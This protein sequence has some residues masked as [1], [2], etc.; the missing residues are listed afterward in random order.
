MALELLSPA[1]DR[2]KL[3]R[4]VAY[5]ADAVYLAGSQYGMRAFAGNFER[6][7]LLEAVQLCHSHGVAVHVT[8]NTNP[9]NGELEGLPQYLEFLAQ[10]QVDALIIGDPGVFRLALRHA[11][12]IPRHISTQAGITN[13]ESAAYWYDQGANRVILARELS[14]EEVAGIK[15]RAPKG[16]EVE[17]FVHGAICMAYSGRCVI[18]N[19]MTGR[20][21][22]RGACAQPC[23]Y[24][25]ALMEEQ[26]PGEYFPVEEDERGSYLLS[27]RDMCMID[28][29]PALLAAGVDSLKIEGRAKSAYYAAIVTGAYRRAIDAA[30]RGEP[31]EAVWREEVEKVS[32]RHYSTGFYY[33]QPGQYTKDSR[34]IRD[35][36]VAAQVVSCDER[37]RAALTLHNKLRTGDALELVGPGLAPVAFAAGEMTDEAGMSMEEARRPDSLFYMTLPCPAP[38]FSYLRR[39]VEGESSS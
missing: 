13:Y 15:S 22:T 30:Q 3:I 5:G 36:Q 10:A 21:A 8:C 14:L 1:G 29:I 16:L 6:G 32:H 4:A 27:S 12:D 35:W 24:R 17:V 11:P 34:Y 23:R 2:E 31:L 38:R 7:E 19:Y 26:R 9:R 39:R 18:S 37:G 20:D 33:G 25:Y 28:H